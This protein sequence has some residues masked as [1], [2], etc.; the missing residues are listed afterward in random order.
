MTEEAA[1][2]DR[3]AVH[4]CTETQRRHFTNDPGSIK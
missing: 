4:S 2:E 1:A 3:P